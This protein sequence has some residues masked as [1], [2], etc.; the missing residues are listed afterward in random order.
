MLYT[1]TNTITFSK[2]IITMLILQHNNSFVFCFQTFY[3]ITMAGSSE[4]GRLIFCKL[5]LNNCTALLFFFSSSTNLVFL[6]LERYLA[7]SNPMKYNKTYFN[8]KVPWMTA[9]IWVV[10]AMFFISYATNFV[11]HIF[12]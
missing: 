4:R 2:Y 5:W 7:I 10:G 3:D 12:C 6:S 8:K 9:G 11:A 1:K